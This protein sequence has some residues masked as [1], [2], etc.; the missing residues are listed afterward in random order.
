M[1]SSSLTCADSFPSGRISLTPL[2]VTACHT[3]EAQYSAPLLALLALDLGAQRVQPTHQNFWE[4]F[5]LDT[6][7][8]C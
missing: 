8:S 5:F 6:L 3:A 7:F 1:T 2:I 4:S